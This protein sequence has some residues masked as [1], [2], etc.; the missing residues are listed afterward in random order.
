MVQNF[1][2]IKKIFKLCLSDCMGNIRSV[3]L[4]STL[5]SFDRHI[6]V[7]RT[8]V[9]RCFSTLIY[10]HP[11]LTRLNRLGNSLSRHNII[12]LITYVFVLAYVDNGRF[13][14]KCLLYF[15]QVNQ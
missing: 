13:I 14:V 4:L 8:L 1:N 10:S 2:T 3:Q 7:D 9:L 6:R 5:T 15:C 11:R 12:G